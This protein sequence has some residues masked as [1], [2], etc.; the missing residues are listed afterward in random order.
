MRFRGICI[1]SSHNLEAGMARFAF[2]SAIVLF[3]ALCSAASL[4][5]LGSG[6]NRATLA[7][8]VSADGSTVTGVYRTDN[9]EA[10]RWTASSGLVKLGVLPGDRLSSPMAISADGSA[11]AGF[12]QHY[13][14]N[15]NP[16]DPDPE[17]DIY[18]GFHWTAAT[19]MVDVGMVPG[20]SQTL[21]T[22]MSRDGST[23]FG[24]SFYEDYSFHAF[25]WKAGSGIVALDEPG[26]GPVSEIA[27]SSADGSVAVGTR[28]SSPIRWSASEGIT[29]LGGLGRAQAVT[30]D[31]LTA[32]GTCGNGLI[33]F[34]A[35]R[36]TAP[37]PAPQFLS[38]IPV[39]A[40]LVSADGSVVAGQ[41]RTAS[42]IQTFRWTAATGLVPLGF[43]PNGI[44]PQ[45]YP[46]AMSDDGSVIVGY[47][48]SDGDSAFIWDA[49]HGM[50]FLKDVLVEAGVPDISGW[51]LQNPTGISA[52][53][54]TIVGYG[55]NF[56]PSG[57]GNI[58][59]WVAVIPEPS[60][61]LAATLMLSLALRRRR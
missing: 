10:F 42:E 61:M 8:G 1:L 33:S 9:D 36:W 13:I 22:A 6:S 60:S 58:E 7:F 37:N 20:S 32:V 31:G 14:P 46:T 59:G 53:G 4:T 50:R 24:H 18:R 21:V 27:A 29:E 57:G 17:I 48:L 35:C 55:Y 45:S 19:G 56:D 34:T 23:V 47:S 3:P 11:I 43:L 2:A 52:D 15:P 39:N 12:G 51:K 28:G 30:P 40:Y 25:R 38:D 16:D 49:Q 44:P 41:I 5:G 26:D 54:N